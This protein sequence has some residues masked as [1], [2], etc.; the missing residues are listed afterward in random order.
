M[1]AGDAAG[2]SVEKRVKGALWSI[3]GAQLPSVLRQAFELESGSGSK[4]ST[5]AGTTGGGEEGEQQGL[6]PPGG[7]GACEW[8]GGSWYRARNNETPAQ[9]AQRA[10]VAVA[11]LLE[12]NSA[13]CPGLRPSA[14]LR[15][16]T[17][18]W[19]RATHRIGVCL[20]F[21]LVVCV[22]LCTPV[23]LIERPLSLVVPCHPTHSRAH[24]C[25]AAP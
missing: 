7:W 10:G 21:L 16:N 12:L 17:L 22:R 25:Q 18:L 19:V 13:V 11:R 15:P 4:P 5:T 24:S 1:R 14:K 23:Y 9:V 2:G 3:A 20:C 8:A 6:A